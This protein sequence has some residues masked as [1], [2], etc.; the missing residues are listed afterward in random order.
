MLD[1]ADRLLELG[2]VEQVDEV[3]AALATAAPAAQCAMFSATMPEGVEEL[4]RSVLNDPVQVKVGAR[5]AGASTVEQRLVF[6]GREQGKAIAVQNLVK[7]VRRLVSVQAQREGST[8][9][10]SA[11]SPEPRTSAPSPH[12]RVPPSASQGLKPPVILFVQSK[13]RA[14]E[15]HRE[16][17]F[18][19]L[20]V[21]AIHADRTPAQREDVVKRFRMGS[22]WML[23][24]TDVMARGVDFK[25]RWLVGDRGRQGRPSGN[26]CQCAYICM[27]VLTLTSPC[28]V[29]PYN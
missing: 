8:L 20:N 15:L 26:P 9:P 4:A 21:D 12:T 29:L 11:A 2:F 19:G 1:E 14:K 5:N 17:A 7:E 3:I 24:A 28:P 13:E 10:C 27:C 16:L 22:V 25:V 6:V 23:V 18:D